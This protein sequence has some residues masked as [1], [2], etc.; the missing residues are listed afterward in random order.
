MQLPEQFTAYINQIC[1]QLRWKKARPVIQR[2][3]EAHLCDQYDSFVKSGMPEDTAVEET[4]RRTGDA[5]E[6]GI[7][8]DRVHRPKP[9]WGLLI[10]TGILLLMGL[11]IKLFFTYNGDY[12]H[13]LPT[14]LV[15]TVLGIGCLFGAY[16]MD[17]TLLGKQPLLVF[18]GLLVLMSI[19]IWYVQRILDYGISY[20]SIQLSLL[21]PTSY[22]ALLYKLRGK[23]FLGLLGSLTALVFAT[24]FCTILP[25]MSAAL[26]VAVCGLALLA[27]AIWDDWF[28][29]GK[30]RSCIIWGVFLL[31]GA[32]ALA[33]RISTS[34]YLLSRLTIA[35][36]PGLDPAGR[37]FQGMLI[38]DVL[39]GAKMFGAGSVENYA[40]AIP[41]Y[42]KQNSLLLTYLIHEIGWISLVVILGLFAV[43]FVF[44]VHQ[45]IKQ[46]NMLGRL[47]SL[48][49]ILTLI[50][51][52]VLYTIYNLGINLL[53]AISL[54]LV[55]EGNT[56]LVVNMALIGIMLSTFRI[57]SLVRDDVS[58]PRNNKVWQ[59]IKERVHWNDGELTIS[60]KKKLA[61]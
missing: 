30:L 53:N 41:V 34:A 19:G 54:P 31:L 18:V 17:F 48:A 24:A 47:I 29:I 56:A 26:T 22:A 50:M 15:A 61:S 7:G 33:I 21:L 55:S 16:F 14:M 40:E 42:L 12:P 5:V 59:C 44:A 51:E 27:A 11:V 57:G 2:E 43:F 32:V 58:A 37:G 35:F 6:I 25:S 23:G 13:E 4:L 49:V 28:Q 20:Y 60:F 45:C 10:L 39:S 1:D 52:I 36:H 8:L 3:M 38:H 9:S 46:K